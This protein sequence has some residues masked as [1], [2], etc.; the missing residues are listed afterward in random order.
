MLA[1]SGFDWDENR[2]MVQCEKQQYDSHCKVNHLQHYCLCDSVDSVAHIHG[3]IFMHVLG[4]F[5]CS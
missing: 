2:K 4:H 3:L 1:K 5:I